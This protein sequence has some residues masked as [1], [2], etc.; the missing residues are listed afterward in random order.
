MKRYILLVS[1]VTV[2]LIISGCTNN[3]NTNKTMN[4]EAAVSDETTR[5]QEE[6]DLKEAKKEEVKELEISFQEI[7]DL[8]KPDL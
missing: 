2:V 1:I 4:N 5:V 6:G 8:K 7:S 3:K